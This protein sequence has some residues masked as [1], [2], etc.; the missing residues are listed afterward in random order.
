MY[1]YVF[2][3]HFSVTKVDQFIYV[4]LLV[5]LPVRIASVMYHKEAL[6]PLNLNLSCELQVVVL[7]VV[8]IAPA[9]EWQAHGVSGQCVCLCSFSDS[10]SIMKAV[11]TAP[12]N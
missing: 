11:P 12:R 4:A 5:G 7:G 10:A 9:R 2:P 8:S 3:L 1:I 6:V